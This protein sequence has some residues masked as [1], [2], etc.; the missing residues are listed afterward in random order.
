[1]TSPDCRHWPRVHAR[2]ATGKA[3][4]YHLQQLVPL[5]S[6]KRDAIPAD[7]FLDI[8]GTQVP[9]ALAAA[10]PAPP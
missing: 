9:D 10:P 6:V 2:G 1:M 8:P 3:G 7:S 4:Q 5:A